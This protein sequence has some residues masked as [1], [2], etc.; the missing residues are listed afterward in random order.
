MKTIAFIITRENVSELIE[1]NILAP[2]LEGDSG[3]KTVAIYFVGDG[4]YHLLKGSRD[5]KNIK[6]IIKMGQTD[7][8]ACENSI[9]NRKLQHI[10]IDD[11]KMVSMKEFLNT[12][13]NVDHIISF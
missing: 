6:T 7:I 11:V 1:D 5:A 9:K 13:M 10:V 8:L 4:V 2:V 3:V 12:T